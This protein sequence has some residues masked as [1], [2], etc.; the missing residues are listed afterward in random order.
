MYLVGFIS[1]AQHESRLDGE[2]L[3]SDNEGRNVPIPNIKTE[4]IQSLIRDR[5]EMDDENNVSGKS[6]ASRRTV[7]KESTTEIL[8]VLLLAL[9]MLCEDLHKGTE[10][11]EVAEIARNVFDLEFNKQRESWTSYGTHVYRAAGTAYG[12]LGTQSKLCVFLTII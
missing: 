8:E 7:E 1:Q 9:K 5:G 11:V 10:A 6:I 2:A 12:L 4:A 3:A